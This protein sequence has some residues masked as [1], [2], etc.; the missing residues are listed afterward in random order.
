M[1]DDQIE[2]TAIDIYRDVLREQKAKNKDLSKFDYGTFKIY[3]NYIL[4]EFD[5]VE[6]IIK[7]YFDDDPDFRSCGDEDCQSLYDLEQDE[8]QRNVVNPQINNFNR[9]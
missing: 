5:G 3:Y 9:R 7:T 6:S 4:R 1:N 8:Y 2:Y